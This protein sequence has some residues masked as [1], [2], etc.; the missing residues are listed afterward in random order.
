MNIIQIRTSFVYLILHFLTHGCFFGEIIL[1]MCLTVIYIGFLRKSDRHHNRQ[2]V[3]F[4]RAFTRLMVQF[5]E[6]TH[7]KHVYGS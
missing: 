6:I 2:K 4:T 1:F 5:T 3:N 7:I